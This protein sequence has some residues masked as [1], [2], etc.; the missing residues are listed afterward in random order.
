MHV[1]LVTACSWTQKLLQRL[2]KDDLFCSAEIFF[3]S[4]FYDHTQE[5][6]WS[7]ASTPSSLM[8]WSTPDAITTPVKAAVMWGNQITNFIINFQRV[9][10]RIAA[11]WFPKYL[12]VSYCAVSRTQCMHLCITNVCIYPTQSNYC[13]LWSLRS[14]CLKVENVQPYC[15]GYKSMSFSYYRKQAKTGVC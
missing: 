11:K 5:R 12:T 13:P 2:C 4:S 6:V 14:I 15:K 7:E 8:I 1:Q 9:D 3:L 10:L